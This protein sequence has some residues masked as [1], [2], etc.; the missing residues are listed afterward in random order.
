MLPDTRVK[1]HY[2]AYQIVALQLENSW[3]GG[4]NPV[5]RPLPQKPIL[6]IA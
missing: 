2:G 6:V 4:L 3:G 5:P 1:L